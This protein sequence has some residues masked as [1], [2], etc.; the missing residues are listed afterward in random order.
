LS[1]GSVLF[2]GRDEKG[3][4]FLESL[5]AFDLIAGSLEP[6]GKP[7]AI[8][9][10]IPIGIR[11]ALLTSDK[12]STHSGP[13][14]LRTKPK[15]PDTYTRGCGGKHGPSGAFCAVFLHLDCDLVLRIGYL[16]ASK[17][18]HSFPHVTTILDRFNT[19]ESDSSNKA[20]I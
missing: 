2:P 7:T 4:P 12:E 15:M 3:F 9:V 1:S 5:S 13:G 19:C 18:P 16:D 11:C 8:E 17:D 14:V 20:Q 6:F 10:L